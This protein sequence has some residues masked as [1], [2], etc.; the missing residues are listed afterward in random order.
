MTQVVVV[1]DILIAE[2][3]AEDPLTHEGRQAMDDEI[4]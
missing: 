4:G 1:A 3:N 2:R